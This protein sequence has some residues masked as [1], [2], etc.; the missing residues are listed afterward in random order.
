M[1]KIVASSRR[2]GDERIVDTI[3]IM[4][5]REQLFL[6]K[7]L[8]KLLEILNPANRIKDRISASSHGVG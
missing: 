3:E 2:I 4:K 6:V 5:I 7:L 8:A 1:H